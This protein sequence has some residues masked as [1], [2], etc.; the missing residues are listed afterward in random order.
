ML[1]AKELAHRVLRAGRKGDIA[2]YATYACIARRL[3]AVLG[4]RR[5]RWLGTARVPYRTRPAR[6]VPRAVLPGR[7]RPRR[8]AV[9]ALA[10]LLPAPRPDR[11]LRQSQVARWR[12][13]ARGD[14]GPVGW[15]LHPPRA[16]A[17]QSSLDRDGG[18]AVRRSPERR[19]V[20]H[21]G[22]GSAHERPTRSSPLSM[23]RML[24]VWFLCS[25]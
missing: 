8:G 19:G 10:R 7:A 1:A 25:S 5:I 14:H 13:S 9:G 15:F 20:D 4:Q 6:P 11:V 16:R 2:V 17:A 24:W 22:R 18:D 3:G 23:S 21:L 12:P